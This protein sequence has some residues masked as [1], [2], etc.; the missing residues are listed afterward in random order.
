MFDQLVDL[1]SGA[2]WSYLVIFAV[3]Y[4]DAIIPLVPSETLVITAGVLA[5]ANQLNENGNVLR[6]QVESFLREVRAA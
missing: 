1:V 5:S 2:W 3:A 4:L 6:Q